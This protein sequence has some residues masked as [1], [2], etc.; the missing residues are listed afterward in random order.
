MLKD[1]PS[2]VH[3]YGKEGL[4]LTLKRRS[5]MTA[6][7]DTGGPPLVLKAVEGEAMRS[8]GYSPFLCFDVMD[9]DSTVVRLLGLGASLDGPIK[10]PAYGK[11]SSHRKGGNGVR[12]C[13]SVGGCAG[14]MPFLSHLKP[15][16][17][18]QTL[19]S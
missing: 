14:R 2:A 17:K 7:F 5:E 10:Y 8:T 9:M 4:G 1:L 18:A 19:K 16:K 3:F 11:V 15:P 12:V 13:G 6:E